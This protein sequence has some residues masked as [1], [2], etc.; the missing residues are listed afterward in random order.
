[1]LNFTS[2]TG[3]GRGDVFGCWRGGLGEG[4][5]EGEEMA[6]EDGDTVTV[7]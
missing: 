2:I 3:E 1:M 6:V 5:G 4:N 7:D